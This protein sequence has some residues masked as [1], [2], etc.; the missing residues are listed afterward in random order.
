MK[1]YHFYYVTKYFE[2][3]RQVNIIENMI[4]CIEIDSDLPIRDL[5]KLL[6]SYSD[7]TNEMFT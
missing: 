5:I 4:N 1:L 6:L 2:D 7:M 3:F